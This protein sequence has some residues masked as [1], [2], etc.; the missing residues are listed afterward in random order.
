MVTGNLLGALEGPELL[1]ILLIVVLLF[2]GTKLPQLARSLG[3]A[4][5]E[6]HAG[7]ADPDRPAEARANPTVADDETITISRSEYDEL[8]RGPNDR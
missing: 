3:Q 6:F 7:E 5:K 1:I 4:K 8:R 2:G